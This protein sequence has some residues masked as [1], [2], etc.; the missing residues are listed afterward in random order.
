MKTASYRI[1]SSRYLIEDLP[2]GLLFTAG[3]ARLSK[4]S[5]PTIDMVV[6][7]TQTWLG[8]VYMQDGLLTGPDIGRNENSPELRY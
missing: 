3:L 4:T 7:T 5:I 2:T 6:Q 8:K 1:F